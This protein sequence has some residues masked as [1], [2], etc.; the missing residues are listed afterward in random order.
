MDRETLSGRLRQETQALHTEAERSGIMV[1]LLRGRLPLPGYVRLL[2]SLLVVYE[3]LEE[4]LDRH[5]LHPALAPIRMP[6]LYRSDALR[7]DIR[8]LR[9]GDTPSPLPGSALR[10]RE[11]LQVLA[12]GEPHRL[13]AH[14]WVR[15]LGDLSGGR[16]VGRIVARG[17]GLEGSGA[18]GTRFY[19]FPDE[20]DPPIW[21]ERFR[22]ALDRLPL[23]PEEGDALVE[24]ARGAFRLHVALFSE[25][26]DALAPPGPTGS[27]P[28]P[29]P[30][31]PGGFTPSPPG[32]PP[33]QEAPQSGG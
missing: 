13:A 2:E 27:A 21:K 4:G 6:E 29:A 11:R 28:D 31:G 33:P 20:V 9:E 19:H 25:L 1:P 8:V 26:G 14:A 17:L 7:Q 24:E 18:P 5:A 23:T 22:G 12:G 30:V 32:P 15:Y 3:T 10:Y 16:M